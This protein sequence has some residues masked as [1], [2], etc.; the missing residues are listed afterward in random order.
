[1][2]TTVKQASTQVVVRSCS[3]LARFAFCAVFSQIEYS[4]LAEF[5]AVFSQIWCIVQP[6]LMQCSSKFGAVFSQ[7]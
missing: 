2:T 5:G 3:Q 6:N 7:S 4:V 1:M